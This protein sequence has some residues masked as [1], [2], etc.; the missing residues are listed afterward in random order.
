MRAIIIA[1]GLG[2]RLKELTKQV[3]KCM[4]KYQDKCL[5]TYQC[6]AMAKAGIKQIA[7]V[8][9][10]KINA[11]KEHIAILE[12]T[13]NIDIKLFENTRFNA[14]NM[15][16][17]LFCAKEFIAKCKNDSQDLLI[18]YSDIIYTS[19]FIQKLKEAKDSFNIMVDKNWLELWQKRFSNP[20]SDAETLKIKDEKIVELGKKPNS[21]DDIEAQYMG[22]FSFKADFLDTV[23][24]AWDNLDKS[25]LY[26]GKSYENM[27]MTSFL[28]YLIDNFRAANAVFAPSAWLEIDS[29]SDLNIKI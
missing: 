27:Y 9:G 14:T 6:E 18:S 21:F 19:D 20:L 25:A 15:V 3:P 7:V 5:I 13:L 24:K 17:S 28:Q 1:A 26:D 22:L 11:L 12:N 29:P 10:Y 16:Y 23:C 8:G 4:V 2:S